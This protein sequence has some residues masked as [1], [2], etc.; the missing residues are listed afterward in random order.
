V[1]GVGGVFSI[2]DSTSSR[3]GSLDTVE[4]PGEAVENL[5]RVVGD[6]VI[7]WGLF[8]ARISMIL[9][10][11]YHDHGGNIVKGERQG[12]P[13]SFERRLKY[14][15]QAFKEKPALRP[16]MDEEREIRSKARQV[17]D[18]RDFI[19]HGHLMEYDSANGAYTF[20]R[21]DVVDKATGHAHNLFKTDV[22]QLML[23]AEILDRLA[24]RATDLF[25]KVDAAAMGPHKP[26]N[27]F[28]R[29]WSKLVA[30]LPF[31]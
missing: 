14:L 22:G 7:N 9:N 11:V 25:L 23:Y 24:E 15:K 5:R 8:E 3:V 4:F 12:I 26:D 31:T 1:K 6:F 21:L 18:V 28:R 16:F 2:R 29:I 10:L 27:L 17:A 19:V 13:V 30:L 20:G